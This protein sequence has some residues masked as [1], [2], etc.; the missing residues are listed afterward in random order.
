SQLV[1][2]QEDCPYARTFAPVSYPI[3]A[4]AREIFAATPHLLH[5]LLCRSPARTDSSA[6]PSASHLA[7]C[8]DRPAGRLLCPD[9]QA[10]APALA[11]DR[12]R[13]GCPARRPPSHLHVA[14]AGPDYRA[15]L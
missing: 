12:Q 15:G 2:E 11:A 9:C 6:R 14:A 4:G 10:L 5:S 3:H 1:S 7:E 8:R 13:A